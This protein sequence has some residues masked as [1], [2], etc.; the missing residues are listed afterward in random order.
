MFCH[1]MLT[2]MR[3]ANHVKVEL[4]DKKEAFEGMRFSFTHTLEKVHTTA[5]G[6]RITE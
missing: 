1:C 6:N 4:S 3:I 2:K 5:D